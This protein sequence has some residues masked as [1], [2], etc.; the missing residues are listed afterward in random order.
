MHPQNVFPFIFFG[1]FAL[2]VVSFVTKIIRNGGLKGALF[3]AP[4]KRT[5]GE[6]AATSPS[7]MMSVTVRVHNLGGNSSDKAVGLEFVARSFA[8]YQ[9]MPVSMSK[10]DAR[11]LIMLLEAACVEG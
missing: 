2:I 4:I 8:S 7:R 1:V 10:V 6:V 11:K 3:G 5:V 9:M